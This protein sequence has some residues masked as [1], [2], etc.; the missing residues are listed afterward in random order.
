MPGEPSV[1]KTLGFGVNEEAA[2]VDAL[3]LR[4]LL[5]VIAPRPLGVAVLLLVIRADQGNAKPKQNVRRQLYEDASEVGVAAPSVES[6]P[7]GFGHI[8]LSPRPSRVDAHARVVEHKPGHHERHILVVSVLWRVV[9]REVALPVIKRP[10]VL[11]NLLLIPFKML[12]A[13]HDRGINF[14]HQVAGCGLEH[15]SNCEA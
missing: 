10:V 12:V 6:V 14:G 8:L 3:A 11:R 13:I 1:G 15:Q 2:R 5:V 4:P 7:D 9:R